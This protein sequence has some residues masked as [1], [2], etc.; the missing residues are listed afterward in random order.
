M[1][2]YDL[3]TSTPVNT[4]TTF[5]QLGNATDNS[6]TPQPT[7][8]TSTTQSSQATQSTTTVP[9]LPSLVDV[10]G[11]CSGVPTHANLQVMYALSGRMAGFPIYQVVGAKVM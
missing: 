10:V 5:M 4:Q 1:Y 8:S 11:M 7:T 9:S 2:Q 3:M 6:T